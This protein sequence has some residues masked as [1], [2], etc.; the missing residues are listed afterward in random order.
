[1]FLQSLLSP[2]AAAAPA[3]VVAT[4]PAGTV[5]PASAATSAN[6]G[7]AVAVPVAPQP[8]EDA[9]FAAKLFGKVGT[10]QNRYL[11]NQQVLGQITAVLGARL[12]QSFGNIF[13]MLK[14]GPEPTT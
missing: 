13:R 7:G 14:G 2:H 10:S 9:S 6:Q 11:A 8:V 12:T 3:P 5:T 4:V 1:M